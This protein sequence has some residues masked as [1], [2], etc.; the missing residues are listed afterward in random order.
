MK[1]SRRKLHQKE[2]GGNFWKESLN[3]DSNPDIK[4]VVSLEVKLLV[5]EAIS[6]DEKC[7]LLQVEKKANVL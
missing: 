1:I 6:E 7:R 2:K 3:L 5:G 4:E